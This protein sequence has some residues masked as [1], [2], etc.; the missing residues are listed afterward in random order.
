MPS[1]GQ[2]ELKPQPAANNYQWV[3]AHGK[4]L[5]YA[6][7]THWQMSFFMHVVYVYI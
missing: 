7:L 1:L 6:A 5:N 3:S 4:E 2:N